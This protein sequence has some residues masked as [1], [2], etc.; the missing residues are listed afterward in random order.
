M[1]NII[2]FK[3]IKKNI[4]L[5]VDFNVPVFNGKITDNT[6][7]KAVKKTI[8][9]LREQNNKIFLLSHF[10]RP[11]G[12]FNKIYSLI[13]MLTILEK[14]LEL[15]KVY[16]LE[17]I[18]ESLINKTINKMHYG[19]VCL[20]EN[21]RFN[22]EEESN[23]LNFSKNLCKNFDI[24]VNDAFSASHRK[25]ASIV[26]LPKFLPSF[27]G[28]GLLEEIKNINFFLQNIK[29]PSLAI[30]GGSKIS[31]KI[32]LLYNLIETFD[33]IVIGG[34]MANTFLYAKEINIG[35]SLCEKKLSSTAL[36]IIDKA[37]KFN[38]KIIL[39][40]DVICADSLVDTLNIVECD[41]SNILSNQMVLDLGN[42]T[43]KLIKE[44]IS[45]SKITLWNGPLGAFEYKNFAKCSQSIANKIKQ[46]S[47]LS[48]SFAIAGGGDTISVIKDAKAEDGFSYISN[49][50]GA[51]LEWLEGKKSPGIIS[52][53]NNM[54]N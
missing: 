15:S 50:G 12:Q 30:I 23:D 29:R 18:T 10:G 34:A 32:N 36:S 47:E 1:K 9:K 39:P 28:Y 4:L 20:I 26:G 48:N 31:T 13:F 46:S 3:I 41:I 45:I 52:L 42:K 44:Y 24:F 6:R 22:K 2:D 11:K 19:E 33:C 14:E 43:T 54:L 27:A 35:K 17:N 49:A 16:F 5:R 38:C 7:I 8:K 25:H 51:F 37:K 40:I 21:I 53:E